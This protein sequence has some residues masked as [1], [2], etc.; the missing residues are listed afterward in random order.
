[1]IN[2]NYWEVI[3]KEEDMEGMFLLFLSSCVAMVYYGKRL[4][5]GRN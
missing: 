2:Y 1:M 3:K 5:D 4:R